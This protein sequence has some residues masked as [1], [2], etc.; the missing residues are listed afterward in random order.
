MPVNGMPKHL[1]RT[2]TRAKFEQLISSIVERTIAPC[3]KALKNA[4]LT[5]KDINEV[6]LVGG[7]TRIPIIQAAVERFFGKAPSKGV[8]PDEVVALGAAIQGGVLTGEVK[9]VLLLDVIPLSLGIETM[10]GVFTKLIDANTTIPTKK[11]EV[12]STASDNQP[13][14]DIHVLQGER[15]MANDNKTLGRFQLT[16]IPSAQRGVPQ[17]EVTFD[18]DANGIM[19]ISAKDKG[20]GKQ[21][22]IKIESASG[23]SDE[24]IQ[25]MKAEAEANAESDKKLREE[26]E[27]VNKAD[28]TIFQTERQ[29]KEYGDKIPADKKQPIEDAL[30]ELKK[31][32][33]AKNV[34]NL[35]PA[36]EK[37]NTVFQAAS[38]EMYN[39]AN[40]GGG[41]GNEGQSSTATEESNPQ[42]EVTDVDFEEV[43]DK[44]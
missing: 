24:E 7:S 14:V 11:S 21:Q 2:L 38:Q 16:D 13:S 37:L 23:L 29:L 3:K 40:A 19:N 36:M 42:D 28:S 32:F 31:E 44:K 4:G 18:I 15:S 20:T 25:R 6:I 26:V 17:I 8:N 9:D 12:F 22:S 39:A 30:A 43:E 41:E 5:P 1:V 27:I 35:E 34:E 10:G 33:D